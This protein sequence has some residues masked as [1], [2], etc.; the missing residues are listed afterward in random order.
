MKHKVYPKKAI[1]PTISRPL[2]RI[3]MDAPCDVE[4]LLTL[5]IN[6]TWKTICKTH[7]WDHKLGKGKNRIGIVH[8]SNL[9]QYFPFV[10]RE[11][12]ESGKMIENL[13]VD[14]EVLYRYT[15]DE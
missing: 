14:G 8:C 1:W 11:E 10:R 12:D 4:K 15:P 3:T 5:M 7:T 13:E 2:G 9:T 6:K